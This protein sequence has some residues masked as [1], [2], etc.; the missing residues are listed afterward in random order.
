MPEYGEV[1]LRPE[2]AA[3]TVASLAQDLGQ[4]DPGRII[5]ATPRALGMASTVARDLQDDLLVAM[6]RRYAVA[7]VMQRAATTELTDA[8][9]QAA[10]SAE[11]DTVAVGEIRYHPEGSVVR[12]ALVDATT[13]ETLARAEMTLAQ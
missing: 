13:R 2:A 4:I 12:V 8:D 3:G 9:V 6:A 7:G 11:A 10:Q 5:I 1:A